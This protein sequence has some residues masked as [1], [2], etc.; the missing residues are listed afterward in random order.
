MYL[1]TK[2]LTFGFGQTLV[3]KDDTLYAG[4]PQIVGPMK[5]VPNGTFWAFDTSHNFHKSPWNG[6]LELS[7]SMFVWSSFDQNWFRGNKRQTVNDCECQW[8][9]LVMIRVIVQIFSLS[10][11]TRFCLF[12]H[13]YLFTARILSQECS[14]LD[15]LQIRQTL[16]SGDP[17]YSKR[18]Q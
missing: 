4:L 14:K 13:L 6:S 16:H 5:R 15:F 9:N 12:T 18:L 17:Y 11:N 2:V 8:K 1:L 7:D 10:C 3:D